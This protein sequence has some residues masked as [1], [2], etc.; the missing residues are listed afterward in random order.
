MDNLKLVTLLKPREAFYGGRTKAVKLYHKCQ[1]GE[2][3]RYIE[4][5]SLYP[6]VCKAG[7]LPTG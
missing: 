2:K 4:V 6:W 5:C 1:E 7:Q 3:I